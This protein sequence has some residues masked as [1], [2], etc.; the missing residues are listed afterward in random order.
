[1][2]ERVRHRFPFVI[3]DEA[4]DTNGDQLALL[5]RLFGQGVAFQRLGDQNQTLYEDPDVPADGYWQP[6]NHTI[7]LDDTRRFGEGIAKFASRLT[8]RTPQV[9]RGKP[10]AADRRVLFLFDKPKIGKVLPAYVRELNNHFGVDDAKR[11]N[12]WAVASRHNSYADTTGGWPKSLVDYHPAYRSGRGART[13]PN[14][15]CAAMREAS[16]LHNAHK[17]PNVVMDL[18]MAGLIEAL[19]RMGYRCPLGR[20]LSS[21]SLWRSL[22]AL[23]SGAP[24]RTRRLLRDH[25]LVGK[26]PWEAAAWAT[27][28]EELRNVLSLAQ[29]GQSAATYLQFNTEGAAA[30]QGDEKANRCGRVRHHP[31]STQS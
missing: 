31:G 12:T 30:S 9:I 1:L 24:L 7:P 20:R 3:L 21:R 23:E 13:K 16:V 27:F 2:I 11:L 14:S 25:V 10:D 28:C 18:L 19:E 15:F 8:I 17:S 6:Q 26:A 22:A 5:D 29:P 4:Q